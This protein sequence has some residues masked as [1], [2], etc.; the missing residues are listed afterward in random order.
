MFRVSHYIH[1]L[2]HDLPLTTVRKPQ[3]PV[4]IWNL[5]RRC[6]LTCK[7]CYSISADIDFPNELTTEQAFKVL[8]DL[9]QYKIP[10]LVLSGGEPL[11]RHDIFE[12][13]KEA[14]R[15]GIYLGLSTNGT[16]IN[17]HNIQQIADIGYDYIGI[18]IDG[19][20]L[21]HDN[22]RQK[23]GAYQASINAI[24]LCQKNN[25]KIGIRFTPTLDSAHEFP[26]LLK[27]MEEKNI[28]K[29][30]LSHLNYSGRGKRN[31][32]NNAYHQQSREILNTLFEHTL[33]AVKLGKN[34]E[35]VTGNNDADGAY[36][37]MWAKKYFDEDR[38]ERLNQRLIQWGGNASGVN[39]ANIDNLGNVHPDTFWWNH[40]LGNVK[41]TPFS[42]I[43]QTTEDT[44]VQKMRQRPRP[45]KG[46][47]AYC[48][49][50][51]ICNGNTRV[52]AFA[53]YDDAWAE[54]PGCYLTDEEIDLTQVETM[55]QSIIKTI[56]L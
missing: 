41:Q 26:Q 1:S 51:A 22:F 23:K 21:I 54:D 42:H 36:L 24:E 34:T 46:R 20:E 44:L 5:I 35:Y 50:L 25:I 11:L 18:S 37:L 49:Y 19:T 27:L 9:D 14:K 43:W 47:C 8:D 7:H 2:Y 48:Q 32:K 13:S 40:T 16:L 17:D 3:A 56:S 29:F 38:I 53:T 4:V 12:I 52:R 28:N 31:R 39:I 55:N 30:Y 10:A 33:A 6:N 15:H 45:V